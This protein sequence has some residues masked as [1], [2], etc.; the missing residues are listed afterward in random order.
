[1]LCNIIDLKML[2]FGKSKVF[3]ILLVAG[4]VGTGLAPFLPFG[5]MFFVVNSGAILFFLAGA[6]IFKK[7]AFFLLTAGIIVVVSLAI[8]HF[9]KFLPPES[10]GP[11]SVGFYN[12]KEKF[13]FSGLVCADPEEEKQ[14]KIILC[15]NYLWQ[16]EKWVSLSG[17]ILLKT[18][19]H[20]NLNYG[21]Q[22]LFLG[23]LK[24]PETNGG[25]FYK[26]NLSRQGIYSIASAEEI[27]KI[28]ALGPNFFGILYKIKSEFIKLVSKI[29]PEPHAS[30]LIGILLGVKT[31]IPRDLFEAF[32]LTGTAHI[33]A[34]S[35]FNIT[36]IVETLR[37]YLKNFSRHASFLIITAIL[38]LFTLITGATS[39]VVRAAI[40]G[41][42]LVLGRFFGRTRNITIAV[43]LA[44][45]IMIFANP[46]IMFFDL[47]FQLSFSATLGLIYLGPIF[48]K[49]FKFLPL[50]IREPLVATLSAQTLSLPILVSAFGKISLVAPFVNV[51]ILP[52]IPLVM[53]LGFFAGV[54]GFAQ[55]V[56][57]KIIG[58]F[59]WVILDYMINV[60][61]FFAQLP[62]A[63]I[64]FGEIS[65]WQIFFYYAVL[66]IFLFE[67]Y[68]KVDSSTKT[69][70]KI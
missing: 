21:D 18:S 69:Q 15:D 6:V 65:F 44:A 7:R 2:K 50:A 22:I 10:F 49:P 13:W 34:I 70:M 33:I 14:L 23:S 27:K 40:M 30:F 20:L 25:D 61:K 9:Q 45:A 19:N 55:I 38:V 53:I 8:W 56:F 62:L 59:V 42:L 39:S 68:Q 11:D 48:D 66:S 63:S 17:K 64:E 60:V 51:L 37:R 46:Q 67:Y 29:F 54:F 32:S 31:A 58:V 43:V 16:D 1:L 3:L 35:G 26:N 5:R 52:L 57:G 24:E 4:I 36:I 41:E 28:N 12:Q 47:G